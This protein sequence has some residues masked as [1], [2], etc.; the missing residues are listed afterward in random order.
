MGSEDGY[1]LFLNVKS[2]HP[3]RRIYGGGGGGGSAS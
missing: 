1:V 3:T 2:G